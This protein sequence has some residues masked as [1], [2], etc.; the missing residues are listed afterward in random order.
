MKRTTI[1]L[2]ALVI[3]I[4]MGIAAAVLYRQNKR[5][6]IGGNPNTWSP[7]KKIIGGNPNTW[8]PTKKIIGGDP[9]TWSPTA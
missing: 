6:P 8:S 4:S 7:T 5:S 3:V 9:R 2:V 1:I